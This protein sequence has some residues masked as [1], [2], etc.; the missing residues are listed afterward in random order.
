MASLER[1]IVLSSKDSLI[2]FPNNTPTQFTCVLSSP[3]HLEGRWSIGLK[4][5]RVGVKAIRTHLSL[6]NCLFDVHLSQVSGTIC[7]GEESTLLRRVYSQG[8]HR[9]D[10]VRQSYDNCQMI[11]VR[12]QTLDRLD[13]VIKP[14][15]MEGHSF[16]PEVVTHA[17]LI[18]RKEKDF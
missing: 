16:D 14:V 9:D 18:L 2:F 15:M 12:V 3:I 10:A 7:D 11:P 6:I 13:V 5:V 1:G 4:D 17:T 8:T